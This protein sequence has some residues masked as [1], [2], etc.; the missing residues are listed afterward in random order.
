MYWIFV[1]EAILT[2]IENIF[3]MRIRIKQDFLYII[4]LIKEF[5]LQQIYF[6]GNI[7]GNNW[8]RCNEGSLYQKDMKKCI[9]QMKCILSFNNLDIVRNNYRKPSTYGYC[10]CLNCHAE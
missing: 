7:F 6:N 4:L 5:S 10:Y 2:D 1:R 3:S 8:C 9:S